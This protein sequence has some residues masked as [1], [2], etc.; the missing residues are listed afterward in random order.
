MLN[1]INI[2]KKNTYTNSKKFFSSMNK[3]S[4][5]Y[6]KSAIS[7]PWTESPFFYKLLENSNHTKE[8]KKLCTQFHEKGYVIIDLKLTDSECL[9]ITDDVENI[10]EEEKATL[11]SEH[12]QYNESPRVFEGWKDS[13]N[14]KNLIL[15]KKIMNTLELLYDKPPV[16]FSSINFTKGSDQP[17]HSDAIHFHTVPYKWMTGVWVAFEDT[18]KYNGTLRVVPGSHKWEIYDYDSLKLSHPD[19]IE[20]GEEINYRIYEDFIRSLVKAKEAEELVVELK[21]GQ[22]L[23]WA[24]NMLHGGIPIYNK[25]STRKTQA[26]H[27]FYDDCD[28]Y[29]HPM[30]S[31]PL[32]GIYAKKWCDNKNNILTWKK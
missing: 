12:F 23:I 16:P 27:Y 31:N 13:E 7:T 26:I 15:N 5:F 17:L 14:I 30:F 25:G 32:K 21:K 11:Q 24:A 29:F 6:N 18:N 8:E 9:K 22:A 2:F 10:I 4:Y 3:N 1:I 19:L 28:E 20:N